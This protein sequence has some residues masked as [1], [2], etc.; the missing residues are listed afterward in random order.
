MITSIRLKNLK[1]LRDTDE[2]QVGK[3]T[4]LTGINGRGKSSFIQSLLL[5]SQSMR[6]NG[7]SPKLLEPTGDWCKLGY[8]EDVLSAHANGPL[9][10]E[11][12]TDSKTENSFIFRYGKSHESKFCGDAVSIKVDGEETISVNVGAPGGV[13]GDSSTY[14]E[15]VIHESRNY[16]NTKV[17][18]TY[19]D[20]A[21]LKHLQNLYFVSA[22][23]FSAKDSE[24][25]V[26]AER[27]FYLGEQGQFVL[28]VLSH[29]ISEQRADLEKAMNEILDGAT[30]KIEMDPTNNR[31]YLY[32]DSESHGKK[33][34][35]INVGYGYSYIISTLLSAILVPKDGILIVENP[36]A[37]LHPQAQ[38]RLIKYLVRVANEKNV[39]CF[40]ETHSDHIV[41]GLLIAIKDKQLDVADTQILYFD[42]KS[43]DNHSHI[44]VSNLELTSYGRV[45]RPPK[46]FCDQYGIDM[47]QLIL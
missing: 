18:N 7:G 27:E 47:E 39:Q 9:S 46:G 11:L 4:L 35:P 30:L 10:I 29:C 3:V 37:H 14:K 13:T 2:C 33:Y 21:F 34:K 15:I 25:L 44:E 45:R 1:A 41:N 8:F 20:I 26:K 38:A 5:L 31:V 36:E 17:R 19:E 23:R 24:A 42:R 32:L 16:S 22:D 28:N 6:K 43:E 12:T 40:I